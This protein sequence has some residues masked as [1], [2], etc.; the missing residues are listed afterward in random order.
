[1]A[2]DAAA[3]A[4]NQ[5]HVDEEGVRAEAREKDADTKLCILKQEHASGASVEQMRHSRL[6]SSAK[7]P[8]IVPLVFTLT[9]DHP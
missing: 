6:G 5:K 1:M 2:A 7:A 8:L 4:S 3:A 9:R